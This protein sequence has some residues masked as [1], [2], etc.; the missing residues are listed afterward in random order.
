MTQEITKVKQKKKVY[1]MYSEI[2]SSEC[3]VLQKW[4]R[5]IIK[6]P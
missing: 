6:K 5:F 4:V 1:F 3:F 2:Q